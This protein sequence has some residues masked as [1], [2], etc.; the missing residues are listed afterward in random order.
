[1]PKWVFPGLWSE[2]TQAENRVPG[3]MQ[4]E[5][6]VPPSVG[7]PSLGGEGGWGSFIG[8]G[9]RVK[10]EGVLSLSLP[11]PCRHTGVVVYGREYFYGGMGIESCAPVSGWL[12]AEGTC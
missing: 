7:F 12:C 10:V 5:L 4:N 1:V 3:P 9:R 8:R 2:L 11:S 6:S